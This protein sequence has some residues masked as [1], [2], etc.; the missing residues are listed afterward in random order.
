MQC[1]CTKHVEVNTT[2]E[3][4]Y[5]PRKYF[6]FNNK[7]TELVFPLI[8]SCRVVD[9]F[10]SLCNNTNNGSTSLTDQES[11]SILLHRGSVILNLQNP[12]LLNP[13]R[14]RS[15][16]PVKLSP[17]LCKSFPI[18]VGFS[19]NQSIYLFVLECPLWNWCPNYN[20][21][22]LHIMTLLTLGSCRVSEP[23]LSWL[24]QDADLTCVFARV[25]IRACVCV[26]LVSDQGLV[27]SPFQTVHFLPC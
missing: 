15:K 5:F 21:E 20:V 22:V 24:V 23:A 26:C 3:R 17:L 13:L 25:C 11:P 4:I 2:A 14:P 6:Y 18:S 12:L 7:T 8:E 1:S 9:V 10:H 16:G 27:L 19:E